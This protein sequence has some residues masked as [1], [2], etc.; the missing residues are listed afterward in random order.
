MT[1]PLIS[2]IVPVFNTEP[3][4]RKCLESICSQSYR[5]LEIICVDDESPDN[6]QAILQEFA[7]KDSRIKV[8]SQKN[9]GLSGARNTALDICTGD[10]VAGVDSDD[11]LEPGIFEKAAPFLDGSTD[12]LFYNTIV[13]YE[14][15]CVPIPA[16]EE[17]HRL[18]Y[19]GM[20]T[21][22]HEKA[23][24]STICFWNKIWRRGL[25]EQ[26]RIRFP[27]GL[28]HEDEAFYYMFCAVAR[29]ACFLNEPGYRYLQRRG[30]I[31]HSSTSRTKQAGL[32][33]DVGRYIFDFYRRHNLMDSS[34][35]L[36]VFY[37]FKT[38]SNI[39][40]GVF[41][42]EYHALQ[43]AYAALV[44]E[45]QLQRLLPHDYRLRCMRHTPWWQRAFITR[46][47]K[48]E[49]FRLFG[50]PLWSNV[51]REGKLAFRTAWWLRL[52]RK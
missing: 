27:Q 21:L 10:Y 33:L 3:Y 20:Q 6:S 42:K 29:S 13:D 46:R 41:N 22:T 38:F 50:L 47:P 16:L 12:V 32:Y 15:G 25:I 48:K 5:N 39:T 49:T 4:L 9:K 17:Y 11:S 40:S 18:K 19:E 26:Y 14:E 23:C 8:I 34:A 7:E 43:D 1:N 31:M 35:E 30:S 2:V 52:L 28:N 51:Y 44:Q 24:K 37:L 45:Q 36:Y